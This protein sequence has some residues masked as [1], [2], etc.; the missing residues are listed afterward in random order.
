MSLLSYALCTVDDVRD[1]PGVSSSLTTSYIERKINQA[2][3][4]IE[5]YTQRRFL[6][7]TYTNEE[8]DG[9]GELALVL[10]QRPVT[11]LTSL[12]ARSTVLN[13]SSDWDSIPSDQYFLDSSAGVIRGVTSFWGTTNRW[14]VTYTAGYTTIPAD[15]REAAAQLAAY[16]VQ[17]NVTGQSVKRR[18]E[19]AREI[20]YVT[21]FNANGGGSLINDLGLDEILARY[22][23]TVV[24]GGR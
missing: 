20:E 17:G 10:R 3:E 14:R 4:M 2:T 22:A 11:A 23:D 12:Q 15:L 7:T 8:Y 24:S 19:G 18:R 9:T 1:T 6:S 5:G 13:D 16:L 21:P